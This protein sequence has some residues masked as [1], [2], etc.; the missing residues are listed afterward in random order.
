MSRWNEHF[1]NHAFQSEWS[2]L[3]SK[4][5]E[6]EVDDETVLTSVQELARLKKVV[7]YLDELMSVLDPELVPKSTW[8]NFHQQ[9][10]PCKQ[11]LISF[12]SNRNIAHLTNANNHADNLLSYVRPW[13]VVEPSSA[14][15]SMAKA[16]KEYNTTI[17]RYSE[18][19]R[20]TAKDLVSDLTTQKER[21]EQ[22]L[23]EVDNSKIRIQ[24]YSN[25]LFEGAEEQQPIKD[26][27]DELVSRFNDEYVELHEFYL[28][29]FEGSGEEQSIVQKTEEATK[30]IDAHLGGASEDVN[31]IKDKKSKLEEFYWKIFGSL[32]AEG[33]PKNNG[34][35]QELDLGMANL[36]AYENEQRLKHQ[37]L[38]E[39]I[40][41]HL[42]RAASA[43]LA[44]AFRI[45]K[46]SFT[47]P[48]V[49]Y[50][51]MFYLSLFLT[52]VVSV[53]AMTDTIVGPEITFQKF[54]TLKDFLSS[55]GWKLPVLGVAVWMAMFSSK[56]RSEA[57]RLKQEYAHKE[58]LASS[59]ISFKKQIEE[60]DDKD[61]EMLKSLIVKAV[62]SIAYNASATLDGKHGDKAPMHEV[63]E[64]L[65]SELKSQVLSKE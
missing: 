65:V 6:A 28:K 40:E 62:D 60:L 20:E 13:V 25:E 7:K 5:E 56:R 50:T 11:E 54:E 23:T 2:V 14:V 33:K 32:D 26:K 61:N 58:A 21:S 55:L 10:E 19:Y 22:I 36:K 8:K 47:L 30:A 34:L 52:V 4:L 44:S 46:K 45:M 35:K 57:Q 17:S 49:G 59:Y 1:E 29:V 53:V 27:V 38:T 12:I 3:K 39:E 18:E 64:K 51:A 37:A 43:G 15:N 31:E 24:E 9:C 16:L 63:V 41:S 48:I 42:P